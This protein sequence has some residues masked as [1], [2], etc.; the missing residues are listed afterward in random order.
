MSEVDQMQKTVGSVENTLI[1]RYR[2]W[3]TT[4]HYI[5]GYGSRSSSVSRED[6]NLS[7]LTKYCNFS[8]WQVI[9]KL[10]YRCTNQH[11]EG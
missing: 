2:Q 7:F 5:V 8:F 4:D 10:S 1:E 6:I 3:S 9:Q 11:Y